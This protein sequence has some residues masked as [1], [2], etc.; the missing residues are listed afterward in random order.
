MNHSFSRDPSANPVID[1]PSTV[2]IENQAI[3]T[4]AS[5]APTTVEAPAPVPAVIPKTSRALTAPSGIVLGDK[6]PEF[7]DIILPRINFVQGVGALKD[8]FQQ[9]SIIFGQ[10][11][12]LFTPPVMDHTTGMVSQPALPPVNLVVF[13]FRPTRYVE[14]IVGGAR[15]LVVN[16]EAEIRANGGT[17]DYKEWELKKASGMRLFQPL[18]EALLAIERPV[19]IA[20]DDTVFTYSVDGKKYALCLWGMKGTAYTAAAKRVFFTARAVGCLSK[21]YPTQRFSLVS[22]LEGFGGTNKAWVPVCIPAGKTSDEFLNFVSSVI[23]APE[24]EASAE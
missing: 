14:K 1:I 9:G 5:E 12:V 17:L 6:I 23:S 2:V 16:T 22:R 20:D 4:P 24:A 10:N 13:G 8:Q 19:H 3:P 11:T 18:A 7:K 15:G 21:G